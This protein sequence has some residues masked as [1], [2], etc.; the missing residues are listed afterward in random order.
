MYTSEEIKNAI[1]PYLELLKR[2]E[3]D[4]FDRCM[5]LVELQ[6]DGLEKFNDD[7]ETM[8]D[9]QK[10]DALHDLYD[11]ATNKENADKAK[12][13]PHIDEKEMHGKVMNEI[14]S[15]DLMDNEKYQRIEYLLTVMK[16]TFGF[17][18]G[19]EDPD[20]EAKG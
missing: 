7:F 18:N 17:D 6:Q 16:E 8:T 5:E 14:I 2:N 19:E 9:V 12:Y 20:V 4:I 11:K 3:N 1:D 13:I 15:Y 10:I